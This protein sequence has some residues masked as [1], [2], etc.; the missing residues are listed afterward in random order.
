M[1]A[2]IQQPS[3]ESLTT[4]HL[5]PPQPGSLANLA[6]VPQLLGLWLSLLEIPISQEFPEA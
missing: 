4:E 1:Q 3:H 2:D 5:A 6:S